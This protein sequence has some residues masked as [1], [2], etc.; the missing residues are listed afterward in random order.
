MRAICKKIEKSEVIFRETS[1]YPILV[2]SMLAPR[3]PIFFK[4]FVKSF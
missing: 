2:L 1:G 3:R 4:G